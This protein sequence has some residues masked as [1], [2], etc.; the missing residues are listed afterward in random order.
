VPAERGAEG[1][2]RSPRS[3]WQ[4]LLGRP[5]SESGRLCHGDGGHG[6]G[7]RRWEGVRVGYPLAT[8]LRYLL[9]II[10][11]CTERWAFTAVW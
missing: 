9:F 10:S 7:D 11:G 8:S 5:A 4:R 6:R 3:L 1:A 2:R